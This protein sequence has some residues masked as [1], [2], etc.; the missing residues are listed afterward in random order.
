[1]L[2]IIDSP[3]VYGSPPPEATYSDFATVFSTIQE[4][5]KYNGY[6][7]FKRDVKLSRVVCV[8]DRYSR[9]QTKG[10]DSKIYESRKR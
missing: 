8:C 10:K 6:A 4:H 7:L 9:P 5:T 1:M 2:P 3:S